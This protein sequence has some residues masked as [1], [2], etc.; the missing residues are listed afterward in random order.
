MEQ[1][2]SDNWIIIYFGLIFLITCAQIVVVYVL[3]DATHPTA[4]LGLYTVYF[5]AALLGWIA[6]ALQQ[7][8]NVPMVVDVPSVASVLNSYLLFLAA[9]QRAG[10]TRGRYVLGA[11]CLVACLSVFF[12]RPH[13]MCQRRS[14]DIVLLKRLIDDIVQLRKPGWTGWCGSIFVDVI[15]RLE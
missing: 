11:I 7:G 15:L 1:I 13:E 4:G 10:I 3:S 5:M 8:S 14:G 12:L 9:G 6:F 2:H